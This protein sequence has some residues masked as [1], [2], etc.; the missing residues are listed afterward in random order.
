MTDTS[1]FFTAETAELAEKKI[2]IDLFLQADYF[3]CSKRRACND[4]QITFLFAFLVLRVLCVLC[5]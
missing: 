1:T 2:R 5:G 3:S 4:D